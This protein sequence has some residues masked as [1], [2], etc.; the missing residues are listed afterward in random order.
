MDHY[1]IFTLLP[2]I[3]VIGIALKTKRT[4]EALLIGTVVTYIIIDGW[5]FFGSWT[6]AFFEAATKYDNVFVL[7]ICGLFGSLITLIGASHGTLGFANWLERH[8]KNAKQTLIM[9][10]VLGI[11]IFID[12][13]LNIM[14]IS[15][16]MKR[17]TDKR[18]TP[19]EA[20]AY[21]IDS[22]GA[23][24]C[25]LLPFSTWAIFFATLFY[26][27]D[28]VPQLGYGDAMGTYVHII[29]FL[30]YGIIAVILVPLFVLNL[31]PKLGAMKTAYNRVKTTGKVY[32]PDCD[33]LN[34]EEEKEY[35]E[36]KSGKITGKLIDFIIPI[37]V[38]ISVALV[39]GDLF[40]SLIASLVTCF[41]LYIPRKKM[42]ISKFCDLYI[43]G[44]TNMVPTLA[45]ILAA[46]VMQNAMEDIG[47]ATYIIEL[48][49]PILNPMI[50]PAITFLATACLTFATGS[51]W[52]VPAVCIPIL[53]PLCFSL[54]ANP[55]FVM[56]AIVSGA[57][58]GSHACFYSDATVLT[59]SCCKIENMEHAL[60]Q[61]PY[62]LM[63]AGASFQGI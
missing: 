41:I 34:K 49:Q 25:V 21:V 30:F 28:G 26:Q 19:R 50:Y 2:I 37:G 33:A 52:G 57:T 31:I 12:D 24:V 22:T 42:S 56:A 53:M 18:K 43:H 16:C 55:I 4:L 5:D 11:L 23:P 39:T 17:L 60:S 54:G 27:Q 58:L 63:A 20:L 13:Y 14:T 59:S 47:I 61:F 48:L 46:F 45:V 51:N 15:T 35:E 44:F 6:N 3:V 29:P 7:I 40:S 8:C 9:S 38:L 1:G 36:E 10:W 62:A 32:A